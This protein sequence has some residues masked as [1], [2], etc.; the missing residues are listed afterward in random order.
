MLIEDV[1]CPTDKLAD[2]MIDLIDMFQRFGY[3]DASCFG[4]AL[5]GNLHLVFAQV[6]AERA[7]H[8]PSHLGTTAAPALAVRCCTVLE[9][10]PRCR[11]S[12]LPACL[13]ACLLAHPA[14]WKAPLLT[15]PPPPP[16]RASAPRRRCSASPT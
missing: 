9:F 2:M 12:H 8:A 11:S 7:W 16:D 5:E 13:P 10:P 14:S 1:A 6:G 15:P 4:H 3:H